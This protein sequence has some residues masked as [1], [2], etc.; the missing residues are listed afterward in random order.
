MTHFLRRVT[1]TF[2][3][4]PIHVWKQ[5]KL[6]LYRLAHGVSCARVH[7]LYGC[8]ESTI[9]K[10][11]LIIYHI[12]ASREGIFHNF[13]H[14][15]IGD[16][17][18]GIIK[19]IIDI[20]ILSNIVVAIISLWLVDL[21]DG[22]HLCLQ[23]FTIGRDS[24]VL[25]YMVYAMQIRSFGMFMQVNQVELWCRLIWCFY[26]TYRSIMRILAKPIIRLH[27]V[28]IQPYLIGDTNMLYMLKI[29]KLANPAMVDKMSFWFCSEW[30]QEGHWPNF[31]IFEES[32]AY[33]QKFQHIS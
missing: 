19:K 18:Q 4:A 33:S 26:I 14:T 31:W 22:L 13:I 12:L 20:T 25:S 17:L 8:S 10:Y 5:I 32:M 29:Y 23:T 2:V 24:I 1:A 21:P 15:P 16:R 3:R 7:N 27:N 6:V 30:S 28:N 11:I 9:N